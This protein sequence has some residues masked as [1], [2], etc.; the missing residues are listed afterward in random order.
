MTQAYYFPLLMSP[1]KRAKLPFRN[2]SNK[3]SKR[4]PLAGESSQAKR[5]IGGSS[6]FIGSILKE[7]SGWGLLADEIL[8]KSILRLK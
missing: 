7:C 6:S 8:I 5:D 3:D 1:P 2:L 4:L